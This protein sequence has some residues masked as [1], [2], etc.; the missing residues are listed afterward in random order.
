MLGALGLEGV[1]KTLLL[2]V[3][4]SFGRKVGRTLCVALCVWSEDAGLQ[5]KTPLRCRE[6][7]VD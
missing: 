5:I 4:V 6:L 1:K 7:V 2:L 3:I